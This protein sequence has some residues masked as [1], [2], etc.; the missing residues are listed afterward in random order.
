M[1]SVKKR[2]IQR[3]AV[4]LVILVVI[5]VVAISNRQMRYMMTKNREIRNVGGRLEIAPTVVGDISVCPVVSGDVEI[6]TTDK[7][8]NHWSYL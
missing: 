3:N 1:L 6:A 5:P 7:N 8:S 2:L 4:G